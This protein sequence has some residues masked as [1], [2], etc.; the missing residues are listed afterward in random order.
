MIRM[1][2]SS[3]FDTEFH[4]ICSSILS[5]K[6][7]NSVFKK[8]RNLRLYSR[9]DWFIN[10]LNLS[11]NLYNK[12]HST[13]RFINDRFEFGNMSSTLQ[14]RCDVFVEE[15][16]HVPKLFSRLYIGHKSDAICDKILLYADADV[17]DNLQWIIFMILS[18]PAYNKTVFHIAHYQMNSKIQHAY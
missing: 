2:Y 13:L 17:P 10:S 9:L 8:K 16:I 4:S 3:Y 11:F 12:L 5:C 15:K 7:Y 1:R 14:Y 18:Q 6:L